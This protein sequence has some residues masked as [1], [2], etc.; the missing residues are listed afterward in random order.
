M[1]FPRSGWRR[2]AAIALVSLLLAILPLSQVL[3]AT[4][5]TFSGHATVVKGT[6]TVA[7]MTVPITLA[8]TGEVAPEGGALSATLLCYPGAGCD[9]NVPDLTN[10]MVQAKVLH[11]ATVAH[12]N[13]SSAEASVAE[14][15]LVNVAGNNISAEFLRAE[16]QATCNN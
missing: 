14:F 12:G 6:V 13:K 2:C 3:A 8:D 16:A 7:G 1:V 10:G 4:Q 5:T 9:V 15:S 11:A